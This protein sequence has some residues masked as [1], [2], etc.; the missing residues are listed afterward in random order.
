VVNSQRKITAL[1]FI[2]TEGMGNGM[3]VKSF[4]AYLITSVSKQSFT[5]RQTSHRQY[6]DIGL[7]TLANEGAVG[8]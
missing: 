5:F 1:S 4:F 6:P 8:Q 2:C 3:N 7:L